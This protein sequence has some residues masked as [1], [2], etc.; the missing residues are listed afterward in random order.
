M[1]ISYFTL[2]SKSDCVYAR[3]GGK[4]PR[5]SFRE[6]MNAREKEKPASYSQVDLEEMQN[7]QAQS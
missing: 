6:T 5:D 3:G 1:V 4:L 7:L 2:S